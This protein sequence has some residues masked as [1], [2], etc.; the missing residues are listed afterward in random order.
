M[1]FDGNLDDVKGLRK[2][3][4]AYSLCRFIPEVTKLKDGND[5]PG[6]TLYEMML[7]IQKHLTENGLEWK[8]IDG[9][10][11]V[12]VKNVLDNVMKQ[13]AEA[14][15]GMVKHQAELIPLELEKYMWESN[16]LG[17][18]TPDKLR[19]TMLFLIG[20]NCGLR[21]GDEHYD[22]RWDGP[23][24][25]SQFSFKHNEK[26]VRCLVHQ[27]DTTTETNDGG[28]ASLKKERKVVWIHPSDN[29]EWCPVRLFDKFV[30]LLPPVK[31]EDA[32]HNLYLRSMEKPN[33]CQWYTTQVV[34]LNTLKK[35]VGNL[36][37]D[38]KFD[39]YFT[40]H[41]LCRNGATRLFQAGVDKKVIRE[42][43]GH[44][45]DALNQYEITSDKQRSEVSGV[46]RGDI[47]MKNKDTTPKKA[48]VSKPILSDVEIN[49]CHKSPSKSVV[50]S[51]GCSY[52][53]TNVK[54]DETAQ[55]GEII[56]SIVKARKGAKATVKIEIEFS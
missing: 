2:D 49:I 12:S 7:S 33:P 18:D 21:A 5:Y 19:S 50:P 23:T 35:T 22:L 8:L 24:R 54:S 47:V 36:L 45:S 56:S 13:R 25:K 39:G 30:S 37:K 3:S 44:R 11:F 27:E 17:E 14:N 43:T 40:N 20:I 9:I 32:K 6:K 26:G 52:K 29:N 51:M 46:L 15:I 10:D 31:S 16:I 42:F 28:L 38:T 4:L 48:C 55:I 1:I 34:G 53:K 41:S